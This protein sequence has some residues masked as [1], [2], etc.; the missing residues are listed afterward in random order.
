MAKL[1]GEQN[2]R[3]KLDQVAFVEV[4][5][6]LSRGRGTRTAEAA[7]DGDLPSA[8]AFILPPHLVFAL[9]CVVIGRALIQG[10]A[11]LSSHIRAHCMEGVAFAHP[12]PT[13]VRA[14]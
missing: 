6:L 8:P 4:C 11:P 5:N 7:V 1:R 2:W 10:V 9:S 3:F 12:P 13:A 14:A